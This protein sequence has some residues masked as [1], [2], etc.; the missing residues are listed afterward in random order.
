MIRTSSGIILW[1]LGNRIIGKFAT[2]I[3][4]TLVHMQYGGRTDVRSLVPRRSRKTMSGV[5]TNFLVTD[6]FFL[7]N[8]KR[9]NEVTVFSPSIKL[10]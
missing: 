1:E 9:S 3:R 5:L 2:I 10:Q 8:F 7:W 6:T 4:P